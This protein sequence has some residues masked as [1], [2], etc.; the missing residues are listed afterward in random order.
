[1]A[2]QRII[3]LGTGTSHGVPM[4]ACDCA[5]CTSS[6]PR[7]RRTR[8]G[9]CVQ[10]GEAALL[11][12]TPPELRLQCVAGNIRR[13]DA[14]LYTHQHADH[15]TGL[16][17]L[18]RFN[19]LQQTSLTCYVNA[20]TGPVLQRMVPYAFTH[21]PHY[22]SAKPDLNLSIIDG[23][24]EAAGVK[25]IPIPLLH[26]RLP[27]LGFRIGAM[28]Y[29]TDCSEIPAASLELL[30]GLDVLVLDAL[31]LRPH[32]THFNL[33]Q[34]I[35]AAGRIGARRTFFTHIAHELPHAATNDRLPKGMALGYDGQVIDC[36]M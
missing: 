28:A 6:D 3:L 7:D 22:V 35:E 18:R 5:V 2:S 8:T 23:P 30:A 36:E 12:D 31:R 9:A 34:A 32:P 20:A 1:M 11:I 4:I 24:F 13:A 29:C 19:A 16:D 10:V 33:D 21:D 25:V 14:V 17:D 15:I 27:I 26:G